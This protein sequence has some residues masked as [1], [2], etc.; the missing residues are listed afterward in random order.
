MFYLFRVQWKAFPISWKYGIMNEYKMQ[1]IKL[2]VNCH[3]SNTYKHNKHKNGNDYSTNHCGVS[4]LKNGRD[5]FGYK[6]ENQEALI[7][8]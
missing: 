5:V 6:L 4:I 1:T 7:F 8:L 2:N 3:V